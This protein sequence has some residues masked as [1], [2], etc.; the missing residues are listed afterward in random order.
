MGW[1]GLL[2]AISKLMARKLNLVGHMGR[3]EGCPMV[4]QRAVSHNRGCER[5]SWIAVRG[6]RYWPLTASS[7]KAIS[8][9]RHLAAWEMTFIGETRTHSV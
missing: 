8:T 5:E 1:T 4:Y 9:Y 2:S 3:C 6:A 7:R